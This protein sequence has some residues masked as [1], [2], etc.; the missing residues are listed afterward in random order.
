MA[1][2]G[3]AITFCRMSLTSLLVCADVTAVDVLTGV[4][5]DMG[6]RAE[7]RNE[8]STAADRIAMVSFDAV[9]VDCADE[10]PAM[11][12]IRTVHKT[13]HTRSAL[14]IALVDGSNNV[15]EIFSTG[16]NFVIYK[17]ISPE[18]ASA[19]L[20][21]ACGL[22]HR[23]KRRGNRIRLHTKASIAYADVDNAS[24][25]LLDLSEHGA[26]IQSDRKLPPRCKVYFQFTLPGQVSTVRLSG[27]VAWQDSG[28]RV[29]VRFV[30][31]PQASRRILAEWIQANMGCDT[32]VP[33]EIFV[34]ATPGTLNFIAK[35][36]NRVE[37]PLP[38]SGDRRIKKRHTCSIGAEVYR[39]GSTVPYRCTLTDI[40]IGGCYVETTDPLP[41]GTLVE[42]MVHTQ[43]MKLRVVGRVQ[44]VH[45]GFGMGVEFTLRN[46][47]QRAQVEEL[48]ARQAH[49]GLS[50]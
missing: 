28:G 27:E 13:E 48:I 29:G 42:I 37:E 10:E 32:G 22:M 7:H 19:S 23:E 6:V 49:A 5:Q 30:D 2:T 47:D 4:L 11:E 45:L 36:V 3:W 25:T 21:A 38:S 15:K 34:P 17:P 18:R 43:T 33:Q 35:P 46:D 31:V 44:S 24:A 41:S 8:M 40:S 9:L 39:V 12:L 1:L 14:A 20:R 50:V 26:A 16:A